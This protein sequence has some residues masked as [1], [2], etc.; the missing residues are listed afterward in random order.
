MAPPR[1]RLM[2][3]G[4]T[5]KPLQ[6]DGSDSPFILATSLEKP[7][8]KTRKLIRS[9]VMRGRN[10][11][12]ARRARRSQLDQVD[13]VNNHHS[14]TMQVKI[15]QRV[16]GK[17]REP[18]GWVAISPRR[19]AS[20]LAL[21]GIEFD[22]N[23]HSVMLIHRAFTVVKPALYT[24]ES[25]LIKQPR[26]GV[27]CFTNIRQHPA[28]LDLVLF[29]AQ[30]FGNFSRRLDNND[31]ARRYLTNTLYQLQRSLDD[32]LDAIADSTMIVVASL[33][34]A[35]VILGDL[36]AAEKHL[37]GLSRMVELRGGAVSLADGDMLIHKAQRLD[38]AISMALGGSPRFFPGPI[39]WN[40]QTSRGR[41][42]ANKFPELRAIVPR[43]EPRLLHTW[44]DLKEFSVIANISLH[45]DTNMNPDLFTQASVS[46]PYR[47]VSLQYEVGSQQELLRLSMLAYIKGAFV[48]ING[49]GKKMTLLAGC[50][51]YTLLMQEQHTMP[52]RSNDFLL[53]A[54]FMAGIAI[55]E[56]SEEPWLRGAV[57]STI[58][59]LQLHT[60]AEVRAI[61]RSYLW[62]DAVF[63]LPGQRFYTR[64]LLPSKKGVVVYQPT[65]GS[66]ADASDT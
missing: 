9:H 2:D 40:P 44:A 51:R 13:Q 35:A 62:V 36:E 6:W 31:V 37:D 3:T 48:Q 32:P 42:P 25:A 65:E 45:A 19:V 24:M 16:D 15:P 27:F 50:L 64:C 22:L 17:E 39:S 49:L 30:S 47:L 55:F 66:I 29:M 11:R 59:A 7:D 53:W 52:H 1:D 28:M 14:K 23:E 34:A 21:I 58:S 20:E 5:Q 4:D 61:V 43:P 54:L 57:Q 18:T 63:D 38:I 12:Q 56:D 8:P 10:T 60:W 46:V 33:A 26:D 41:R